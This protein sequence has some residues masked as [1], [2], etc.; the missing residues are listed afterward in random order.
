MTAVDRL[1]GAIH[2]IGQSYDAQR[3][4]NHAP[5]LL[6]AVLPPLYQEFRRYNERENVISKDMLDAVSSALW[7][8]YPHLE[9]YLISAEGREAM[10][11]MR[12]L[13]SA[14]TEAD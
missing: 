9:R 14:S 2:A 13:L 11:E 4:R 6:E 12:R 3:T 5:S 10:G 7:V 1:L 8:R